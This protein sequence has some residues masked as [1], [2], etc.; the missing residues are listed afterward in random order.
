MITREKETYLTATGAAKYLGI[1]RGTFY[2]QYKSS[3]Q[4]YQVGKLKRIH[5]SLSQVEQLNSVKPV[6]VEEPCNIAR[7]VS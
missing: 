3:L 2:R 7:S 4:E 6:F 5:Y 1:T